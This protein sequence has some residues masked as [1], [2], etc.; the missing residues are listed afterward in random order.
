MSGKKRR[1]SRP[2]L[3]VVRRDGRMQSV[4]PKRGRPTLAVDDLPTRIYFSRASS[5]PTGDSLTTLWAYAQW[6][7]SGRARKVLLRGHA[8][9]LFWAK[10]AL[11]LADA[12]VRAVRDLLLWLGAGA[13]QVGRVRSSQL[14]RR[15]VY[16]LRR[17]RQ[18][19]RSV[20]IIVVPTGSGRMQ[21]V[22]QRR[23]GKVRAAAGR[24]R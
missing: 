9:R 21:M 1:N 11:A 7:A 2:Q 3:T 5:T 6:L 22:R 10:S 16:S 23:T 15:T 19:H 24:S 18:Q 17:Q 14:H 8:N 13:D 12:R 4:R 20:E